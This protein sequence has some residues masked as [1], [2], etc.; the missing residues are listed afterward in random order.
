M[1]ASRTGGVPGIT[2][3]A[4]RADRGHPIRAGAFRAARFL[5]SKV[6]DKAT[7]GGCNELQVPATT[8]NGCCSVMQQ[9]AGCRDISSASDMLV[10][11]ARRDLN[12][13]Q[14]DDRR[15][16]GPCGAPPPARS[17]SRSGVDRGGGHPCCPRHR[18]WLERRGRRWRRTRSGCLQSRVRKCERRARQV[19]SSTYT[20]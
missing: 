17:G 7:A 15:A 1:H 5:G 9:R 20:S 16:P 8:F 3:S 12:G 4:R 10:A 13:F 2:S 14:E 19:L 18:R 11:I 6:L